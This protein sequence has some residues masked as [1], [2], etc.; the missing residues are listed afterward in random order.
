MTD[1][2]SHGVKMELPTLPALPALPQSHH[3]RDK[4]F[5]FRVDK[6]V[7]LPVGYGTGRR[8]SDS[9]LTDS[10]FSS[11]PTMIGQQSPTSPSTPSRSRKGGRR[12]SV[13]VL[14]ALVPGALQA[15]S[16]DTS[17]YFYINDGRP[18]T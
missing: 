15:Y 18:G 12:A 9:G 8:D 1:Q 5:G 6:K 11:T 2:V 4:P 14:N 17:L 7:N 3:S 16:H 13:S 10:S